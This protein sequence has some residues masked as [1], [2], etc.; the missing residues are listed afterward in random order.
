MI[1]VEKELQLEGREDP[2]RRETPGYEGPLVSSKELGRARG[3]EGF[4]LEG[5]R[6]MGKFHRITALTNA[7]AAK[8]LQPNL[9]Q[10]VH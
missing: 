5:R 9:V 2:S 7:W 3:H 4:L 6:Q 1:D 10:M 8:F